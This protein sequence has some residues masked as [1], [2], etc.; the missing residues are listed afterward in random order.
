M[1]A[2]VTV[3]ERKARETLRLR[4]AAESIIAELPRHAAANHGRYLVFGSVATGTI[5]P[6]SDFD[7]LVDFPEETERAAIDAVETLCADHGIHADVHSTRTS[8]PGFLKRIF[9]HCKEIKSSDARWADVESD[10]VAMALH[11][12]DA[13]ELHARGGFDIENSLEKYARGYALMHAMQ[14]GH[15]SAESV[16]RRILDIIR[17]DR[18]TGEDWHKAL[19][20]RLAMPLTGEHARPALLPSKV[21]PISMRR[22]GFD[23]APCTAMASLMPRRPPRRSR[24]PRD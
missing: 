20:A 6:G 22:S 23:T 2:V 5:R 11:F 18:P 16:M 15:T 24:P 3:S 9:G 14:S 1:S 10:V 4:K 13:V 17:E 8:G 19:I 12:G 7:V 21:R